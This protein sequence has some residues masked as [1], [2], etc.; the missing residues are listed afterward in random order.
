MGAR[1]GDSYPDFST[2]VTSVLKTTCDLQAAEAG[3][4]WAVDQMTAAL[5]LPGADQD[6]KLGVAHFLAFHAYF[7]VAKN[8]SIKV[9]RHIKQRRHN[10][11]SAGRKVSM[12]P[13]PPACS[14]LASLNCW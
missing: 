1:P 4:Q 8:S 11:H 9:R 13:V 14:C 6:L 10:L 12:T 3:R 7:D 2:L 5:A